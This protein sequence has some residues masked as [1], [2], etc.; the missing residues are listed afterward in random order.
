MPVRNTAC[1]HCGH[2][3]LV[4]VPD[5]DTKIQKVSGTPGAAG[6]DTKAA[7]QECGKKFSAYYS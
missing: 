4:N 5:S 1:P 6:N 7:C 3:T 2:E